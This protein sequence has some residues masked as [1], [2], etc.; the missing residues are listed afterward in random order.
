[1][2]N[3]PILSAWC[4]K[5]F[6]HLGWN[7]TILEPLKSAAQKS[8][9]IVKL[10]WLSKLYLGVVTVTGNILQT[11]LSMHS[12]AYSLYWY[13]Y[14]AFKNGGF[15]PFIKLLLIYLMSCLYILWVLLIHFIPSKQML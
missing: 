1:M 3:I 13:Y 5:N 7:H 10:N 2:A 9:G 14:F 15:A 12:S 4:H 11:W 6:K 8:S